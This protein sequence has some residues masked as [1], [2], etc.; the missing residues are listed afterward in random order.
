MPHFTFEIVF[1]K[2]NTLSFTQ[3]LCIT[4]R[5][6]YL[7]MLN[8]YPT[9]AFHSPFNVLLTIVSYALRCYSRFLHVCWQIL[10]EEHFYWKWIDKAWLVR[11]YSCSWLGHCGCFQIQWNMFISMSVLY[12]SVMIPQHKVK[13]FCN[14]FL[15]VITPSSQI[16]VIYR[17]VCVLNI[18]SWLRSIYIVFIHK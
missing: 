10:N 7:D 12:I 14:Y 8:C 6:K 2:L 3:L 15:I 17:Y 5:I 9:N 1:P 13:Y 18:R 16:W 4:Q 11:C